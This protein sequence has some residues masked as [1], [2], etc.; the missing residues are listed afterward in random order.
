MPSPVQI[1]RLERDVTFSHRDFPVSVFCTLR[2]AGFFPQCA[3]M[4]GV[5]ESRLFS[6]LSADELQLLRAGSVLREHPANHHI[7]REGDAGDGIYVVTEGQVLIS[8]LV[9]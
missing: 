8:A 4:P 2:P 5:E 6:G 1:F 9:G 3:E 7:F